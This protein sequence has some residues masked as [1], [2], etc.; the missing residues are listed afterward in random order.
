VSSLT[1]FNRCAP[2]PITRGHEIGWATLS[3]ESTYETRYQSLLCDFRAC[4]DILAVKQPSAVCRFEAATRLCAV[5]CV[6]VIVPVAP[7]PL[8]T[9]V[10]NQAWEVGRRPNSFVLGWVT[11]WGWIH[12]DIRKDGSHCRN[13]SRLGD[14][15]GLDPH[16]YPGA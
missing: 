8:A 6:R 14:G 5:H 7:A 16:R 13:P 1:R 2:R 4:L 11:A 3:T 9:E 15:V 12:I 10:V